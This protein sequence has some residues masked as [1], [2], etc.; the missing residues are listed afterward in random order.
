MCC[1]TSATR[2]TALPLPVR[3]TTSALY[4]SGSF[5]GSNSTSRTG[6]MTWT[7]LPTFAPDLDS[8][9]AFFGA[10]LLWVAMSSSLTSK[11]LGST[12]DLC[13]LLRDLRLPCA[14][15]RAPQDVEHVARRV[16]R[17]LHRRATRAVF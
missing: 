17:I 6:P 14:V 5:S 9:A 4:S 15:E 1:C 10:A 16:G 8:V 11:C 12:D 2:R 3:S 13:Q 7:T